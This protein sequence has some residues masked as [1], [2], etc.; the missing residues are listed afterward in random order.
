MAGHSHWKQIKLQKG[1]EDKKRSQLFSKLLAAITVAARTEPNP[2]FNPRLRGAI[3]KAREYSVPQN[4]IKK[5]ISNS[6]KDGALKDLLVEAY[7]KE[8]VAILIEAITNNKNR[9]MQAIRQIL[10]KFDAKVAMPG[11][12]H[13]AFTKNNDTWSPSFYTNTTTEAKE[14]IESLKDTLLNEEDIQNVITNNTIT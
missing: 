14:L 12:A 13:W 7:G 3:E 6:A 2:D 10:E 5:A 9:T 1:S 8:G 4:N 11:S